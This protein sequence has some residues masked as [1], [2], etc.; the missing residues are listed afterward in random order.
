M[1]LMKA[2]LV[3]AC[4]PDVVRPGRLKCFVTTQEGPKWDI[5]ALGYG[6]NGP[7]W[8]WM[9]GD[10]PPGRYRLGTIYTIS[11]EEKHI[12]GDFCID[13]IDLE[14]QEANFGRAGISIHAGRTLYTPTMGCVRVED[15]GLRKIV[16]ATR[17]IRRQ[18]PNR[19]VGKPVDAYYPD[20]DYL[21]FTMSWV[22]GV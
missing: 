5:P 7:G 14:G 2:H 17:W 3:L 20:D 22:K 15:E 19:Q 10:T 21:D 18:T 6:A 16:D 11:E 8:H 1:G 12:F 9:G 13:L 4:N